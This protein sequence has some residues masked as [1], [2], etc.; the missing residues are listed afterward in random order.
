MEGEKVAQPRP[1][2]RLRYGGDRVPSS[3]SDHQRNG[4]GM[5]VDEH[6]AI[7]CGRPF[8]DPSHDV[9][10]PEAITEVLLMVY[11]LLRA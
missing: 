3:I 11:S 5:E 9:V 4:R 1:C 2:G 6:P 7:D 10:C 8:N